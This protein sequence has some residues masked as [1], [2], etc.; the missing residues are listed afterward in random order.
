MMRFDA[1]FRN[2]A[3][4]IEPR[5]SVFG[6]QLATVATAGVKAVFLLALNFFN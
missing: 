1:S 4:R 3:I 6:P 5:F 2:R